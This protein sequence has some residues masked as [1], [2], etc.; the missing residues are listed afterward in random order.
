MDSF[1]ISVAD[2]SQNGQNRS[3]M[4]VLP[5]RDSGYHSYIH[6]VML[7]ML[8]LQLLGYYHVI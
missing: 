3:S 6:G 7:F 8:A 5:I 2:G 4:A 1:A